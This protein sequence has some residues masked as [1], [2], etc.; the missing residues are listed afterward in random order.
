MAKKKRVPKPVPASEPETVKTSFFARHRVPLALAA[1]LLALTWAVFQ[2]IS[3]FSLLTFGD[4]EVITANSVVSGG[5]SADSWSYV[6]W[7]RAAGN[8]TPLT[9]ISHMADTSFDTNR[10]QTNLLLH[11]LASGLFFTAL[12][13]LTGDVWLSFA[14]AAF[15]ALHPLRAQSVAWVAQRGGLLAGV[16]MFLS[17]A[18]WA[19]WKRWGDGGWGA[20][21]LALAAYV[22][23]LMSS[24]SAAV[25]PVVLMLLEFW[26]LASDVWA[27]RDKLPFVGLS[28]GAIGLWIMRSPN[29]ANWS[30]VEA[31]WPA[32]FN[33]FWPVA[34]SPIPG[35]PAPGYGPMAG[36]TALAVLA[37]LIVIVSDKHRFLLTGLGWFVAA[38]VA[39]VSLTEFNWHAYSDRLTYFAHAGLGIVLVWLGRALLGARASYV[40]IPLGL[41]MAWQCWVQLSYWRN[42]ETLIARAV[43]V[44]PSDSRALSLLAQE[45]LQRRDME[46]AIGFLHRAVAASPRSAEARLELA[47]ALQLHRDHAAALEQ[48]DRALKLDPKS[49][50]AQFQRGSVLMAMERKPEA[51][52][53]FLAALERGVPPEMRQGSL[54]NLGLLESSA[55]HLPEAVRYFGLVLERDPKHYTA[56]RELGLVRW[57]QGR[58]TEAREELER[59]GPAGRRDDEVS[60]ALQD[61]RGRV[62]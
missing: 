45:Y 44:N 58:W 21:A 62:K 51:S 12:Y 42:D 32:L 22:L 2:T 1:G 49:G 53:A 57:K 4:R 7:N 27:W 61:L 9:W 54:V 40:A 24:P 55:G 36:W 19:W 25:L 52:A 11:L 56:R 20:Y 6:F 3:D 59:L 34:L 48:V 23:A 16:F 35:T 50:R 26:P 29:N 37:G 13:W 33:T 31:L 18:A 47:Q 10:H 14:A 5:L 17:L 39:S 15:F 41:V 8:W 46:R 43:E 60:K 28:L 30:V 38:L